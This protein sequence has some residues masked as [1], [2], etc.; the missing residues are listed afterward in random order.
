MILPKEALSPMKLKPVLQE[1]LRIYK[2]NLP[3]LLLALLLELAL[4]A[5]ALTPL[6]CLASDTFAW[7][8]W[9]C[10][11]LYLLIV[12][13]AR[14]NYAL[15]L[16]DMMEGGRVLSV[17]LVSMENYGGKL[18]R[19]LLGL[20]RLLVW[21]ALPI[22][23]I[24]ALVAV[25][26]G[27]VDGFTALRLFSQLGGGSTTDGVFVIV[28]LI[29]A[30]LLLPL[31]GC[32]FHSGSRHAAALGDR[33]LVRGRRTGLVALWMLGL[34]LLLPFA[35]VLLITAGDWAVSFISQLS[36]AL[37]SGELSLS[38]GNRVYILIAAVLALVLPVL[39]VKNMLPAVY[40]RLAKE[41]NNDAAA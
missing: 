14:Q 41:S 7:G 4:R 36:S 38:L 30:S 13:P 31:F 18:L 24:G 10:V 1:T 34:L 17:R 6:M 22:A 32:A 21:G 15:A 5:I 35:A 33:R 39:P 40:L 19:G 8:A 25:Y 28:A 20:A 37:L 3:D 23:G 16:Q 11:P 27:V 26:Y 2:K 29:A 12:L 9:L